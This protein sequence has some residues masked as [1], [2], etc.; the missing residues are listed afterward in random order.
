M[1]HS[2]HS[3]GLPGGRTVTWLGC[4][5]NLDLVMG[6]NHTPYFFFLTF[7]LSPSPSHVFFSKNNGIKKKR[8]NILSKQFLYFMVGEV[9][10][11]R[12]T[13]CVHYQARQ[14]RVQ[15]LVHYILIN[16][17]HHFVS[18]RV[19]VCV[20]YQGACVCVLTTVEYVHMQYV[21][22]H[23]RNSNIP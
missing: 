8:W 9:T 20:M 10:V 1:L 12:R 21:D 5:I 17:W 3:I 15:L 16:V 7:F 14:R 22:Q 23:Q 11:K 4:A 18:R 6:S 13:V 19:C 2:A